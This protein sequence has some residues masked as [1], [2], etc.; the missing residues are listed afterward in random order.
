MGI[1]GACAFGACAGGI[2]GVFLVGAADNLTVGEC[3]GC[4]DVK[5]AIGGIAAVCGLARCRDELL[6]EGGEFVEMRFLDGNY[7]VESFHWSIILLVRILAGGCEIEE[8]AAT[9]FE[10]VEDKLEALGTFIVWVGDIVVA[11]SF[12]EECSHRDNLA[13]SLDRWSELTEIGGIGGIH[14]H[15]QVKV[16][17][18]LDVDLTCA[19]SKLQS[20]LTGMDTHTAVGE[21]ADMVTAGSG[22]VNDPVGRLVFALD[23]VA[24][25][26][27]GCG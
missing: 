11:G 26:T 12:R 7:D 24:H 20:T 16:V 25:D 4:A 18:I 17:E 27:F 5:F 10:K 8:V 23:E 19:V 3:D 15:N 14:S 1:E 13:C 22:R 6:P 2:G 21:V 9:V